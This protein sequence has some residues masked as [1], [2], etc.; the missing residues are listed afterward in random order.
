MKKRRGS[1][2][3]KKGIPSASIRCDVWAEYKYIRRFSLPLFPPHVL[4]WSVHMKRSSREVEFVLPFLTLDEITIPS[5]VTAKQG[6]QSRKA[7]IVVLQGWRW[8]VTMP[9][10][11]RCP[12]MVYILDLVQAIIPVCV[13]S[14]L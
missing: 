13:R 11:S 8:R 7:R 6:W 4:I 1:G 14:I 12:F 2:Q 10:A 9:R 3:R 5:M